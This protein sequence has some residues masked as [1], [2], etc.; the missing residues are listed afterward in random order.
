MNFLALPWIDYFIGRLTFFAREQNI[1]AMFK[2][3]IAASTNTL[4][5]TY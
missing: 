3:N 4:H 1:T 2:Y 5:L